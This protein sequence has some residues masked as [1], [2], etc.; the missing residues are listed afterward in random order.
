LAGMNEDRHVYAVA[1]GSNRA[2]RGGER[3]RD[4]IHAAMDRLGAYPFTL[5]A[6]SSIIDTAPIGPSL[7]RYANAAILIETGLPPLALLAHL[8][9]T[10]RAFGRCTGGQR[11]SARALDLD[12]ILWSGGLWASKGLAIPHAAFRTRAFVLQPLA[13]IAPDWRDPLTGISIRQLLHRV[14]SCRISH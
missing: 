3:P 13:Q 1:V 4:L 9:A 5:L 6:R 14:S 10:E 2:R 12:I 11:W 7:R 8:K